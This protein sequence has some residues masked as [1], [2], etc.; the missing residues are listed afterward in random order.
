MELAGLHTVEGLAASTLVGNKC[1]AASGEGKQRILRTRDRALGLFAESAQDNVE[2]VL[3]RT[4]RSDE[5]RDSGR[6]N[7][8]EEVSRACIHAAVASYAAVWSLDLDVE[9]QLCLASQLGVY[10]KGACAR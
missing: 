7:S 2:R 4:I 8:I 3:K 5:D 9:W 1:D 10:S 6:G